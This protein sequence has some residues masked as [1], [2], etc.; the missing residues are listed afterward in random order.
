MHDSQVNARKRRGQEIAERF[1][2][3]I[4]QREDGIWLVPSSKSPRKRYA[5]D[6]DPTNPSCTCPDHQQTG[7]KC[8]HI[9]AVLEIRG[10]DAGTVPA[11]APTPPRPNPE[12]DWSL[13]NETQENEEDEFEPLLDVICRGIREPPR[14]RGRPPNPWSDQVFAAT[15]KVYLEKSARRVMSRLNRAYRDGYLTKPVCFNT[16]SSFLEKEAATDIL[17]DLIIRTSFAAVPFERVFAADSTGFAGS[18]FVRWQDIKYRGLLEH[19]W[20]KM[21]IMAGTETHMIT[22]VVIKERDAADLGQLPE[23]LRITAQNFII[24]EVLCD[25]VYNTAAN[26]QLIADIGAR[27]FIPPKS[28]HTGRRGGIFK[29]KLIEWNENREESLVHYGQ[30][31]QVE[32]AFS[33]IKMKFGDSLR[34]KNELPMKNEALAKALCHNIYCLIRMVHE[35]KMNLDFLSAVFERAKAA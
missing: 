35:R 34:S 14:E 26:Q 7:E 18:K 29:A 13:Y 11:P 8:K 12:R 20:A 28:T 2:D 32:T 25:R 10:G 22:A 21:H 9:F 19:V 17:N 24:E 16:I 30:R 31:A 33:M 6:L 15:S 3:R 23:L 4:I 1:K 27:A 5:V